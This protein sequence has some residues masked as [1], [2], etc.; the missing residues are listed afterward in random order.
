MNKMTLSDYQPKLIP[1]DPSHSTQYTGHCGFPAPDFTILSHPTISTV[2][3]SEVTFAV[4]FKLMTSFEQWVQL[5][6][7]LSNIVSKI[8]QKIA[9]YPLATA[10]KVFVYSL[11]YYFEIGLII[12]HFMLFGFYGELSTNKAE[13][14]SLVTVIDIRVF[15]S[16]YKV[17]RNGNF[18]FKGFNNSKKKLPASGARPGAIDYCWFRSPMPYHMS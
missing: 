5:A 9:L 4:F 10:E 3:L 13:H 6:Q 17:G 8:Q 2:A 16:L 18:V 15:H 14:T 11:R 7:C 12:N 1:E